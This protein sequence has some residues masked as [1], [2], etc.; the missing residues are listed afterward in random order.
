M[1]AQASPDLAEQLFRAAESEAAKHGFTFKPGA[2]GQ[3]RAMADQ[4]AQAILAVASTKPLV[5]QDQYLK[6]ALGVAIKAMI[7]MVDEMKK[8]HGRLPGY[9]LANQNVL[10]EQTLESARSVLCPIWPI[11]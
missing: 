6:D 2:A 3:L 5:E 8:A 4:G 1:P 9:A 11:C 10:G 7:T